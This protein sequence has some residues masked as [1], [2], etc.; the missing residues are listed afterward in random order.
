MRL[1]S[2]RV[3]LF[4][5]VIDS[6]PVELDD[7]ITCLVGK[8]EAGKTALLEAL[9][10]LNPASA[11]PNPLDID[12]DYPRW[13]KKSHELDDTLGET[14]PISAEF[15]LDDSERA[16]LTAVLGYPVLKD[17][18]VSVSRRYDGTLA[19]ERT[20]DLSGYVEWFR[21]ECIIEDLRDEVAGASTTTELRTSLTAALEKAK[22]DSDPLGE[23]PAAV[24]LAKLD[25][26][27]GSG[28]GLDDFMREWLKEKLPTTFYFSKYANLDG[29]YDLAE[30]L[31]ALNDPAAERDE[32]VMTAAAFLRLAKVNAKHIDDLDYAR[33]NAELEAMSNLL[34]GEVG[35][36]WRQNDHL[37][38]KVD[39]FNRPRAGQQAGVDKD[40]RFQV[41]DTR[42]HFTNNLDRRSTGFRWFVSFVAAFFEFRKR[43]DLILLLD[44]PGLSLHARAQMDLLGAID[45]RLSDGRQ[46]VYS[47]HSPFMVRPTD[48]ARV[49]VVEDRG[50]QTGVVATDDVLSTDPDTLFPLQAALGYDIAQ[51]LFIGGNNV[52]LEGV[53]DLI[54]LTV[55]SD[56]LA[57]LGRT[58]LDARARLVPVG[59]ASKI[60]TFVALIGAHL[61]IVV[62]VDGGVDRQRIDDLTKAGLLKS[63]HVLT[64]DTYSTVKHADIEDM[65]TPS[66]YLKLYNAVF[67][68]EHAASELDGKDRIVDRIGREEGATFEQHARVAK[69]FASDPALVGRLS[70]GTLDR[71]EQVISDINELVLAE[72]SNE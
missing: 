44:E 57:D 12:L 14:P 34:T 72:A 38:L 59:G 62:L 67:G 9:N 19:I 22:E 3:Q 8:N 29:R 43:D 64:V 65:F 55:L 30:V 49:R 21:Q 70:A 41:E 48:L 23:S 71:F 25:E 36:Y 54:Y 13:L 66:E 53:S 27:V 61:P 10:H 42:H 26:L 33:L 15:E 17:G 11:P 37:R 18:R 5:N 28:R 52:L 4:R 58:S 60:P 46:T 32:A 45:E 6:G 7:E 69:H 63:R 31:A 24:A 56:H 40:L 2:F 68:T 20:W 16:E 1:I 39:V 47:T 51:N 50:P 35:R